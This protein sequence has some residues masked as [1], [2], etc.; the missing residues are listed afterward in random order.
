[1]FA[2]YGM[3]FF[4]MIGGLW[5]TP[6]N[7]NTSLFLVWSLV[8]IV[9]AIGQRRWGYYTVIPVSLLASFF[10]LYLTKWVSKNTRVA[11]VAIMIL[12]LIIPNIRNTVRLM[13]LPNNINADWYVTLT[14]MRKNT[15]DPFTS[16]VEDQ[17][18]KLE[19]GQ[20]I[21]PKGQ[22]VLKGGRYYQRK[23]KE[24]PE[25]GVLS[26]W[27]Y[28]HWIIRIARRVPLTSPTQTHRVPSKFLT[29]GT[30]EEANK[31]LKNL[32]IRYIII[33]RSL[34]EGKWYAVKDR[35]YSDIRLKDS[36][37]WKLWNEEVVGW[38]KIYERGDIKIYERTSTE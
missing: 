38:K 22:Y 19:N 21:L 12:F 9:A 24:K 35:A 17:I 2:T 25:Y 16:R 6:K 20:I 4:L 8:L 11:V 30:E 26:W 29:S 31:C 3:S 5:F 36:M 28:G 37:L 14:W 10:T 13:Y 27:D 33:D 1:M 7:K 15:P 34:L 18:Y 32:N 23:V